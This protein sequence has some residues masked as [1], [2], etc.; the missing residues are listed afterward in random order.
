VNL[1]R[2]FLMEKAISFSFQPRSRIST[3]NPQGRL[4]VLR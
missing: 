4:S 2:A 1:T 3:V